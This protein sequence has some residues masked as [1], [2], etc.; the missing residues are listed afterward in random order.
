[1]KGDLPVVSERRD[2]IQTFSPLM[3]EVESRRVSYVKTFF[4]A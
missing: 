3:G 1:M 2:D 4:F